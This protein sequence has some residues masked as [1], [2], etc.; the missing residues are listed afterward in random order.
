M[1]IVKVI[2]L[3]NGTCDVYQGNFADNCAGAE[4]YAAQSSLRNPTPSLLSLMTF[5]IIVDDIIDHDDANY[6][7]NREY[8]DNNCDEAWEKTNKNVQMNIVIIIFYEA[9][10]ILYQILLSNDYFKFCHIVT[11]NMIPRI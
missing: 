4:Y 1:I 9:V 2:L 6:D 11:M 5:A 8:A 10:E 3:I 7:D